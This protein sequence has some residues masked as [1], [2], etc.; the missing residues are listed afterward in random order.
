M[1]QCGEPNIKSCDWITLESV[2]V[3]KYAPVWGMKHQKAAPGLLWGVQ[4]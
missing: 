1:P 2:G 3:G 4:G